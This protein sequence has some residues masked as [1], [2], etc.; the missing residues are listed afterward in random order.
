MLR[1]VA[2]AKSLMAQEPAD[3]EYPGVEGVSEFI[4]L[5]PRFVL[6][7]DCAALQQGRV[8]SVQA[9]SGTGALRVAAE[10]LMHLSSHADKTI[11]LPRPSWGNHAHIFSTV[12]LAVRY[13]RYLDASGTRLD[14]R[15]LLDDLSVTVPRGSAVLM[16]AA[17]HNPSGVDP[18]KVQ[19]DQLAAVCAARQLT[20]IMDTAVRH[21]PPARCRC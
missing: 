5:A 9:L 3:H 2:R 16:H 7:D 17:A 18:S 10:A 13:Y 14:W 1:A 4:I 21:R 15:G 19:W 6:G 8:A 11:W 20:P 12:G